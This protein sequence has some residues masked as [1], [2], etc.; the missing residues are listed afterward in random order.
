MGR[1]ATLMNNNN[2]NI[3]VMF[4][5]RTRFYV[6][7]RLRCFNSRVFLTYQQDHLP[8]GGSLYPDYTLQRLVNR[9]FC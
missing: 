9:V 2:N 1:F 8:T 7:M 3:I 6:A 5:N 4:F